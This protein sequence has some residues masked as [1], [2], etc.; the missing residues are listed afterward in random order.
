MLFL[1]TALILILSRAALMVQD[2]RRSGGNVP[3]LLLVWPLVAPVALTASYFLLP[4]SL[5][6]QPVTRP[7]AFALV[8]VVLLEELALAIVHRNWLNRLDGGPEVR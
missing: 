3:A 4:A 6:T 2:W 7:V 5:L 1:L 8:T